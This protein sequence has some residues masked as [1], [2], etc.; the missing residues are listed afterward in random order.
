MSKLQGLV[1][2]DGLGKLKT[3]NNLIWTRTSDLWACSIVP[4]PNT[5]QRAPEKFKNI[6]FN[7]ISVAKTCDMALWIDTV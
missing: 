5:L 2:L 6:R 3:F 7:V 4:Q 1:R